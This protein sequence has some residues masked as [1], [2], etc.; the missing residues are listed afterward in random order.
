MV[1]YVYNQLLHAAI[2]PLV[3][4]TYIQPEPIASS[5]KCPALNWIRVC[6]YASGLAAG[7]PLL[8]VWCA[9]L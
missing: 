2:F 7:W 9:E 6:K 1:N 4:M 8:F 3:N 5:K